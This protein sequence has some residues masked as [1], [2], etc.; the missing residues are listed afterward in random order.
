MSKFPTPQAPSLVDKPVTPT[1]SPTV[2]SQSP[3]Q[4]LISVSSAS[5]LCAKDYTQSF[6]IPSKWRPSIMSA[7]DDKKLSPDIRNEIVRDL[8]TH[9]YGFMAKP[10][11]SFCQFV[12]QRLILKYDFMR[13]SKGTGSVSLHLIFINN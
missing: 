1:Q 13:D 11:P 9:M 2:R 10:S 4:S 7:I 12:A 6:S 3:D 8:V 5:S